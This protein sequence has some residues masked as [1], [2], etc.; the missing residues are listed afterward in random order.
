M[1]SDLLQL[2]VLFLLLMVVGIVGD[3]R[4]TREQLDASVDDAEKNYDP[5]VEREKGPPQC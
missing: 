3:W 4:R 1:L 2:I 5:A